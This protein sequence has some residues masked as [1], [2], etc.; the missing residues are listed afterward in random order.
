MGSAAPFSFF[1]LIKSRDAQQWKKHDEK[2]SLHEL[3]A[4]GEA[5]G[6]GEAGEGWGTGR[7][8]QTDNY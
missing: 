3:K 8:K 4:E 2:Q 5:A 6:G 7:H 1:T